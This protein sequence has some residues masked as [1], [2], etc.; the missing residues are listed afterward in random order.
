MSLQ[1]PIVSGLRELDPGPRR[2]LLFIVFNVMS[3]QCIVGPALVLFARKIHM[4]PS[5]VGFLVAFMPLSTLLVVVTA[6]AV[7]RMGPK[8]VMFTAWLSRNLIACSVF[9]MPLAITLWGHQAGWYV[10]MFSTLG[11]SLMRAIGSGGWFPWLHEVVPVAQRGT[12]FSTE[13]S[14]T[15]LLNVV[16]TL[17]QAAMLLGDP[18]VPRFLL[19]YGIGI[20]S[21][22]FSLV[23]MFRVPGGKGVED[24]Q[25]S[26]RGLAAYRHALADRPFLWFVL[27]AS[28]C[29][30]SISWLGTSSVLYMRDELGLSWQIM[31]IMAASSMGVLLTIRAWGRFAD[32]SGSAR[33]MGLTLT[34]HALSGL[35]FLALIPG[36]RWSLILIGPATILASVFSTAFWTSVHRAMLNYVKAS[37]RVGYTN[38]WTIG[39]AFFSGITPVVAGV[40]IDWWGMWGYRVCFIMSGAMGLACAL[41]CLWVVKESRMLQPSLSRLVDPALPVRTIGRILWISAGLHESNRSQS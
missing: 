10:L 29:F 41:S 15:Q 8:R 37:D 23:W 30:S 3:W 13:A 36:A 38:L 1:L 22:L 33:A 28:L 12:Y 11:F 35:A 4:P 20:A 25:E 26:R 6:D 21:G 31:V 18:D 27:T 24:T 2:F 5:W 7:R 32:H 19:I 34:G 40:A 39:T 16:L 14:V 9:F 17:A